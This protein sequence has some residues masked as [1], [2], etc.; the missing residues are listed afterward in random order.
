[1]ENS[2]ANSAEAIYDLNIT[3]INEAEELKGQIQSNKATFKNQAHLQNHVYPNSHNIPLM[4][5]K[6]KQSSNSGSK[7]MTKRSEIQQQSVYSRSDIK[8]SDNKN[9]YRQSPS[10]NS[11]KLKLHRVGES[12]NNMDLESV[13]NPYNSGPESNSQLNNI[14]STTSLPAVGRSNSSS[15]T[16]A[17]A[18]MMKRKYQNARLITSV[19]QSE[20]KLRAFDIRRN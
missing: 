20:Q 7:Q 9:A 18:A 1:M 17:T 2:K 16:P 6:S 14:E 12:G 10:D 15:M 11:L 8:V 4:S 13:E 19:A 3:T 5:N